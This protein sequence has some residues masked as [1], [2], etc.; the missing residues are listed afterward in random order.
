MSTLL[1]KIYKGDKSLFNTIMDCNAERFFTRVGKNKMITFIH[2]G[3]AELQ[4]LEKL[5]SSKNID[6]KLLCAALLKGNIIKGLHKPDSFKLLDNSY[7][8]N[9]LGIKVISVKVKGEKI[10]IS[11]S[12]NGKEVK[13]EIK[14]D[15]SFD[16]INGCLYKGSSLILSKNNENVKGWI[17][18]NKEIM[19][20]MK[21]G[22]VDD[23]IHKI[24]MDYGTD[25]DGL[26]KDFLVFLKDSPLISNT[27]YIHYLSVNPY[28]GSHMLLQPSISSSYRSLKP[29]IFSTFVNSP[30]YLNKSPNFTVQSVINDII[31]EPTIL[32]QTKLYSKNNLNDFMFNVNSRKNI[33]LNNLHNINLS[34]IKN[35]YSDLFSMGLFEPGMIS[36][37]KKMNSDYILSSIHNDLKRFLLD[38]ESTKI[39]D[40]KNR[41]IALLPG[42]NIAGELNNIFT[43]D[44]SDEDKRN[45]RLKII[46]QFINSTYFMHNIYNEFNLH[47][48]QSYS[49]INGNISQTTTL[50]TSKE[51]MFMSF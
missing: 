39:G 26:Y 51:P 36:L 3:K 45:S 21:G 23:I 19:S 11:F 15:P 10:E 4:K 43:V 42:H 13:Q 49:N 12:D 1:N 28:V 2:P 41:Y 47:Y 25:Y 37:H 40:L 50:N 24:F 17:L 18:K 34:S 16:A 14:Y 35:H 7:I 22:S 31:N 30:L 48:N 33:L 29:Q 27:D 6:D 44:I 46:K 20:S 38:L 5:S 9:D 8:L 32:S